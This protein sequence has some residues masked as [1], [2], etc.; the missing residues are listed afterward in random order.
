MLN[1]S[2]LKGSEWAV[3][4]FLG[5]SGGVQSILRFWVAQRPFDFAQGKLLP[6]RFQALKRP[7]L[8]AEDYIEI[9]AFLRFIAHVRHGVWVFHFPFPL[10]SLPTLQWQSAPD[11]GTAPPA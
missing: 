3:A 2:E 5:W 6:L 4:A 9:H 7:A 10:Q 8:A 1:G 11:R